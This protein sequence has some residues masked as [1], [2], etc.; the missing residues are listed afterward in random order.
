M[1]LLTV[2]SYKSGNAWAG[3]LS[4]ALFRLPLMMNRHISFFKLMGSGKN[5]DF[6]VRPDFHQWA[7]LVSTDQVS[8]DGIYE[9]VYGKFIN[10][11]WQRFVKLQWTVVLQPVEGHGTWDGKAA[12][13]NLPRNSSFE[14]ITAVLTRATIRPRMAK[15]FWRNVKAVSHEM[16]AAPGF[17]YSIGIGE[18]P[19]IKQATFS[20]WQSKEQMKQFAYS[21]QHHKVVIQRTRKE[22]WYSEDMFVRFAVI[23]ATGDLPA[24]LSF[25]PAELSHQSQRITTS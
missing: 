14:G 23:A 13:G 15:H 11:W 19:W 16:A 7:V 12:F 22:K 18:M 8:T 25:L 10:G 9:K 1:V 5:G 6:D 20:I 24:S 17:H 4:M 3:M 21:M 2:V